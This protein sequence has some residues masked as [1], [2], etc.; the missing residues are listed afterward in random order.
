MYGIILNKKLKDQEKGG[1][2]EKRKKALWC[3]FY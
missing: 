1:R 3:S 2:S